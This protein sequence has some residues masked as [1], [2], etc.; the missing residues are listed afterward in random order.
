MA[1]RRVTKLEC[2]TTHCRAETEGT[3]QHCKSTITAQLRL[4]MNIDLRYKNKV[5][6]FLLKHS[7]K[8]TTLASDLIKKKISS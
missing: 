6:R 5:V 1:L 4:Q 8:N 3:L 2:G 7:Y